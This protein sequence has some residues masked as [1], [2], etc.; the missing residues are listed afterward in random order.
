MDTA[1]QEI[2][3]LERIVGPQ[4]ASPLFAR[5]ADLYLAAGRPKDALRVCDA[6]LAYF[7]FYSTGHFVKGRTLIALE[8]T[9][10]AR[11]ELEFV[12][13]WLPTNPTIWAYLD[14]LPVSDDQT[15]ALAEETEAPAEAAYE[16]PAFASA[17]ASIT[18]EEQAAPGGF[19]S[20]ITEETPPEAAADTV[21][22]STSPTEENVFGLPSEAPAGGFGGFGGSG[23]AEESPQSFGGF[24]GFGGVTEAPTPTDQEPE[25]TPSA[26]VG[27]SGFGEAAGEVTEATD[28]GFQAQ[29][30]PVATYEETVTNALDEGAPGFVP[31]SGAEAPES[32]FEVYADRLRLDL[33]PMSLISLD[34]FLEGDGIVPTGAPDGPSGFS[35][36][37]TDQAPLVESAIAEEPASEGFSFG[38]RTTPEPET[39]ASFG[40]LDF[41]GL[42]TADEAAAPSPAPAVDEG[43]F[44]GP[45]FEGPPMTSSDTSIEGLTE[46]LQSAK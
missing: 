10:E 2:A 5:L 6:G 23:S 22:P 12:R 34:Q 31:T 29:E 9:N 14:S 8:M 46:K 17:P 15:F 4:G 41:N 21:S 13:D 18:P 40:G 28:A 25:T 19:F 44:S 39:P 38:D 11:R 30:E 20:A 37:S 3:A 16:E 27:F 36:E 24:G 32:P 33:G 1:Q 42:P 26:S 35:A 45:A 7:P 43:E